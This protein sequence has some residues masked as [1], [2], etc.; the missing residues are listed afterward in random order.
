MKTSADKTT[1]TREASLGDL[2]AFFYNEFLA[3]YGDAELAS[4]ATAAV[5][6]E[7]LTEEVQVSELLAAVA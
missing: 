3:V 5:I 1:G 2:I 6:N 4:V 7:M